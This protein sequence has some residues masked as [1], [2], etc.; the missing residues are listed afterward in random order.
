MSKNCK[1]STNHKRLDPRKHPTSPQAPGNR[2]TLPVR[3]HS[4]HSQDA[5]VS[6]ERDRRSAGIGKG[7]E[8]LSAGN[9]RKFL[10][11][12]KAS[13][14]RADGEGVVLGLDDLR[15]TAAVEDVSQLKTGGVGLVSV[16]HAAAHVRVERDEEVLDEDIIGLESGIELLGLDV[17]VLANDGELGGVLQENDGLVLDHCD[18]FWCC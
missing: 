16:A 2:A 8:A 13:H 1:N 5:N 12:D 4:R 15:H 11:T 6:G 9:E 3:G 10:P 17:K 14:N 7:A 18:F